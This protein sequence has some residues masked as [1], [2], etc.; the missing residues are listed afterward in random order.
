M[1][2][3]NT[4]FGGKLTERT[5][6]RPSFFPRFPCALNLLDPNLVYHR[7]PTTSRIGIVVERCMTFNLRKEVTRA[8]HPR[9]DINRFTEGESFY[10]FNEIPIATRNENGKMLFLLMNEFHQF[11]F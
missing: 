2:N 11:V 9:I 6:A 8:R 3:L 7:G 4:I 5:F 10:L 1:K